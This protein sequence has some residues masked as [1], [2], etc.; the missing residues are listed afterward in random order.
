M[1]GRLSDSVDRSTFS[2]PNSPVDIMGWVTQ[3]YRGLNVSSRSKNS[4]PCV[5]P[6]LRIKAVNSS[7]CNTIANNT[8]KLQFLFFSNSLLFEKGSIINWW[9]ISRWLKKIRLIEILILN[10]IILLCLSLLQRFSTLV[11]IRFHVFTKT[12]IRFFLFVS[13]PKGIDR[14]L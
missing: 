5:L 9:S 2:G 14:L 4:S 1:I 6:I 13:V 10:W 3:C 12:N 7:W 8:E 11:Y